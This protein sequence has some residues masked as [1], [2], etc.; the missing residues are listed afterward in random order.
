MKI[1][2]LVGG[3]SLSP[4]QRQSYMSEGALLCGARGPVLTLHYSIIGSRTAECDS[5]SL[6]ISAH[7]G[8]G[9]APRHLPLE[10]VN[11]RRLQVRAGWL[12]VAAVLIKPGNWI[13]IG[14]AIGRARSLVPERVHSGGHGERNKRQGTGFENLSATTG[15]AGLRHQGHH[16]SQKNG[17]RPR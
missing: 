10:M 1:V 11:V 14:G 7:P 8:E 12:I 16:A 2:D 13:R 4:E 3:D 17:C 6:I 9:A 15:G 5:I